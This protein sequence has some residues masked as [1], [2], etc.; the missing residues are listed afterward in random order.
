MLE[1]SPV[2]LQLSQARP[3][4]ELSASGGLLKSSSLPLHAASAQVREVVI[5][6]LSPSTKRLRITEG[7]PQSSSGQGPVMLTLPHGKREAEAPGAPWPAHSG[8]QRCTRRTKG[9]VPCG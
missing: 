2:D 8:A 4:Q 6:Q 1:L 9:T 3:A 5:E 7:Q